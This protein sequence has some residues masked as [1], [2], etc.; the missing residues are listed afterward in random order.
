MYIVSRESSAPRYDDTER[1]AVA[2]DHRGM[3]RFE[4]SRS[5]VFRLVA[6]ALLCYCDDAPDVIRQ[7][8]LD[9]A[10]ALGMELSVK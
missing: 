1:A 9:A 7:R 6:D 8:C 2:A 10:Q 4:T 3:A 5:Q